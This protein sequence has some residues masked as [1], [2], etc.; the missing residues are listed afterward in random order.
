MKS[1]TQVRQYA[2]AEF[3]RLIRRRRIALLEAGKPLVQC[4][5]IPEAASCRKIVDHQYAALHQD[6]R[7]LGKE[8]VQIGIIERPGRSDE[9]DGAA[10]E[11]NGLGAAHDKGSRWRYRRS[12]FQHGL[13]GFQPDATSGKSDESFRGYTGTAADIER[14]L[15]GSGPA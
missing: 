12:P 1:G 6:A 5:C 9:V 13:R 14:T 11:R 8:Q 3:S 2:G 4:G 15:K 10:A 7:G